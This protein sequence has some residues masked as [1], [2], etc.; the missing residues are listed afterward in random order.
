[1]R[2]SQTLWAVIQSSAIF[3]L[4]VLEPGLASQK[5]DQEIV[6]ESSPAVVEIK[7]Q[8]CGGLPTRVGTGFLVAPGILVT[9][10]HVIKP[11]VGQTRDLLIRLTN[12]IEEANIEVIYVDLK[13]DLAV[14]SLRPPNVTTLPMGDVKQVHSGDRIVA[15]GYPRF[16]DLFPLFGEVSTT[17]IRPDDGWKDRLADDNPAFDPQEIIEYLPATA[18]GFS[19]GPLID[20]SGRVVGINTFVFHDVGSGA[21][22]INDVA[23]Y[24]NRPP[25][26][27]YAQYFHIQCSSASDLRR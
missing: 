13:K 2:S 6:A 26:K 16:H 23:A 18:F 12:G 9:N 22:P 8:L 27:G 21:I 14:L 24:M 25:I 3:F 11:V 15:I 5:T 1:M 19:G 20:M 4:A 10:F 7:M 17:R